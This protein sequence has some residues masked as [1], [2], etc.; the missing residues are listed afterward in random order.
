MIKMLIFTVLIWIALYIIIKQ[1]QDLITNNLY[2]YTTDISEKLKDMF[3]Y[4]FWG[5]SLNSRNIKII[6]SGSIL[7]LGCIGFI[8]P[9]KYSEIEIKY[10]IDRAISH[11]KKENYKIAYDILKEYTTINSPLIHHEFAVACMGMH[12]YDCAKTELKKT[13]KILP[14]Y[15]KAHYNLSQ[16]YA[17]INKPLESSFELTRAKETASLNISDQ[18]LYRIS[19]C[20]RDKLTIRLIF[21]LFFIS[22]AY[23]TPKFLLIFLKNRRLQKF[24]D[25]LADGLIMIAN[26][27]AGGLSLQESLEVV[28]K[29]TLAP[30]NQEIGL[31]LS[32]LQADPDIEKAIKT[33]EERMPTLDTKIVVNSIIIQR[34]TG[35]DLVEL[36]DNIANTIQERKRVQ[37]KIKGMMA[38]NQS[39]AKTLALL[40]V[41]MGISFNYLNPEIFSIMY[42]TIPGCLFLILM[43]L[44]NIT[45]L[46]WMLQVSKVKV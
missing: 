22:L 30:F 16:V 44:M 8:I 20:Y 18:E 7:I 21:V 24:D 25:Q 28:R 23:F 31:V 32:K 10:A 15:S 9:G 40:P 46:Y 14:Q 26:S 19:G 39:Q 37:K 45:G 33:L 1:N 5:I 13:I 36:F 4:S 41:I 2:K 29:E 6:L 35:I 34:K 42:T 11:N 38:S 43:V 12:K 17:A 3:I 27:L